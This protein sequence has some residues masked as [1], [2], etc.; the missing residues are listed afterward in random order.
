MRKL[1]TFTSP[2]EVETSMRCRSCGGFLQARRS[3]REAHLYC[4]QCKV[5]SEVRE[6]L[7]QMDKTLENFL[8]SLH[9]DRI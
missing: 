9:C 6:Y 7:E 8:E 1:G 5:R 4:G 2:R 3:C